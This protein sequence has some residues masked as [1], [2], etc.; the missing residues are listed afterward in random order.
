M[1]PLKTIDMPHNAYFPTVRFLM[2]KVATICLSIGCKKEQTP[3]G[4]LAPSIQ[5]V[6][7]LDSRSTPLISAK[8]GDWVMI[9]G[10]NLATTFKVDFNSVLS[11]DSLFYADDTSITVRIPPVL[12]DPI[13]NPITVTTKYGTATYNFKILQPAPL[14]MSFDPMAGPAGTPVTIRGNYFRGVSEV[15]FDN[16]VTPI[17]SST[18][19]Q[20]AVNV[21]AGVISAYI[22]VSTPVGTARSP[23]AYGFR[24]AIYEDALTATWSN[25]SYSATAVVNNT[26]NLKRG[27]NSIRVNYT[28]G[29]GALRL[30]KAN[31]ALSTTG[32]TALKFSVFVP[33]ASVGRKVKVMLNGQTATGVTLTFA[34]AGWNDYQIPLTSLGGYATLTSVT[35]QE[36]SSLLQELYFDDIALF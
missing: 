22:F 27:T 13:N 21:P 28:A 25:T 16:T 9:K 30:S 8:Y 12:P 20:I 36:F 3:T 24:Y 7:Y 31:P 19:T 17:I 11:P 1:S 2:V 29:F 6:A 33:A 26:A 32:Y 35:I 10:T 5:S 14:I 23:L 34:D 15:R 18:S 4:S